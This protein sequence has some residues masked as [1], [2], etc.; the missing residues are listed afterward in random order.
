MDLTPSYNTPKEWQLATVN[1]RTISLISH[2]SKVM[3][4]IILNRIQPQVEEIIAKEQ[5]GFRAG[6]SSTEQ[7]FNIRIRC[8]K[9][10][11][12]QQNLYHVFIE[13]KKAFHRVWHKANIIRV[14]KLMRTLILSIFLYACES[15]TLTAEL[16]RRIQALEM[17]CYRRHLNISNKDHM[18]NEEVRNTIQNAIGVQNDILTM[19]KK[20]KLRWYGHISRSSGVAKTVLKDSERSKERKIEDE[21]GR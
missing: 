16:E 14:I 4:Q 15:W 8:K 20:R 13:L 17:R 7:I 3:L 19:V 10:L 11:H 5:A 12:H 2:P 18:T 1:Y 9:Y 21:I 6:R